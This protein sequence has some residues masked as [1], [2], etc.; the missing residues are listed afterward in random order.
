[1]HFIPTK[2][3]TSVF[4][5]LFVYAGSQNLLGQNTRSLGLYHD[6]LKSVK[7]E[8]MQSKACIT[9]AEDDELAGGDAPE[10]M[11]IPQGRYATVLFKGSY[12]ELEKPYDWLFGEWLPNSVFEAGTSHPWKNI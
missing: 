8:D 3:I 5:K 11:L 7:Q 1:M 6:D 9:V 12:T 2:A 4:D 10:K